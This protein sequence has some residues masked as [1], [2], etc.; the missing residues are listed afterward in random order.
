MFVQCADRQVDGRTDGR[1]L[2]F[3]LACS[4]KWNGER[5]RE[6]FFL[7]YQFPDRIFHLGPRQCVITCTWHFKRERETFF[8]PCQ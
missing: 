5:E 4:A 3:C 6:R 8:S 1:L 7:G 2:L